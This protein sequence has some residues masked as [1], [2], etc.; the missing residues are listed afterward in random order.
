MKSLR[1]WKETNQIPKLPELPAEVYFKDQN[2]IFG[3][4]RVEKQ[5]LEAS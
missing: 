2:M 1:I 4:Q 5:N 3:S